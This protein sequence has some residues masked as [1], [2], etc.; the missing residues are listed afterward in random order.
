MEPQN[1]IT[2]TLQTLIESYRAAYL[3]AR[4]CYPQAVQE[5][6]WP[7]PCLSEGIPEG[8]KGA[9]QVVSREATDRFSHVEEAVSVEL[10][11]LAKQ[12]WNSFYSANITIDSDVGVL[13]LLQPWNEEDYVRFQQNLVGHLLTQRRFKLP[14]TVFIGVSYE[15]EEV[16]G[17]DQQGGVWLETPGKK[18]RQQLASDLISFLQQ[19]HPVIVAGV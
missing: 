6:D 17:V 1:P 2:S 8:E 18:K 16:V 11:S 13:E 10:S 14:P 15:G 12:Y 19:A 7:S 9:W 3:Q 5:S 4:D